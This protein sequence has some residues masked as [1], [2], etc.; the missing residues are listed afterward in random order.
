MADIAAS[1]SA[2]KVALPASDDI[3]KGRTR[4]FCPSAVS[5]GIAIRVRTAT[6]ASET[7]I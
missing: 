1:A 5:A 6:I 4:V 2:V 3:F 7:E